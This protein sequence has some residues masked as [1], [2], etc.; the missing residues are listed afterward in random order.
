MEESDDIGPR[1]RM[2]LF[3]FGNVD[4]RG[5][6][7]DEY[8]N[9]EEL[10]SINHIDA[11]HV[12]EF[13]ANIKAIVSDGSECDSF[14][15]NDT[16]NSIAN[17]LP[18]IEPEDYYNESEL[19][20]LDAVE[21]SLPCEVDADVGDEYDETVPS[22]EFIVSAKEGELLASNNSST[23]EAPLAGSMTSSS[24]SKSSHPSPLPSIAS[25][26]LKC[27]P[28]PLSPT[29]DQLPIGSPRLDIPSSTRYEVG[30][31]S[32]IMPPPLHP[33]PVAATRQQHRAISSFCKSGLNH[34]NDPHHSSDQQAFP[35]RILNTPLGN[36]L[37]P[38]YADVDITALFPHY[39]PNL[40]PRWGRIISLPYPPQKYDHLKHNPIDYSEDEG[41]IGLTNGES[42]DV[43]EGIGRLHLFFRNFLDLGEIPTNEKQFEEATKLDEMQELQTF[44][45]PNL[46]CFAGAERSW[47]QI[48]FAERLAQLEN[49][50]AATSGQTVPKEV[51][52]KKDRKSRKKSLANTVNG[53]SATSNSVSAT[54]ADVKTKPEEGE[55]SSNVQ[56]R[57]CTWRF[58]P[59]K[60]WYDQLEIP[61]T[62]DITKWTEWRKNATLPVAAAPLQSTGLNVALCGHPTLAVESGT[63][64]IV[65]DSTTGAIA[66]KGSRLSHSIDEIDEEDM[67]SR[68]EEAELE[69]EDEEEMFLPFKLIQWEE[70]I[71]YDPQLSNNKDNYQGKYPGI[72]G[73]KVLTGSGQIG[74]SAAGMSGN[75]TS[76]TI[77][78]ASSTSTVDAHNQAPTALRSSTCFT[79]PYS[80]FPI[81]NPQI[82]DD[83][84]RFDI[85]YDPQC[86]TPAA[87]TPFLLTLNKNDE[88]SLLDTVVNDD[89]LVV[90]NAPSALKKKQPEHMQDGHINRASFHVTF[91]FASTRGTLTGALAKAEKGAE[92]VKRIL[93]KMPLS[94]RF[95]MYF[96]QNYAT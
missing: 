22:S 40:I 1:Y 71:I 57:Y 26:L 5:Q 2:C 46:N 30:D 95:V 50:S 15:S 59:A 91:G 66:Q 56:S 52:S 6:L 29:S 77:A 85:I 75:S 86:H 9:D 80:F 41:L 4:K 81:E 65:A 35:Q 10:S 76:S 62:A 3:L 33:A 68:T 16:S 94:F 88:Q 84:W 12:T 67:S 36:L 87:D 42:G 7:E 23:D 90:V 70:D 43:C 31:R 60:Y 11:C 92:K 83:S 78:S 74:Q 8:A 89:E 45:D 47:W 48:A 72:L 34:D 54:T 49:S 44:P 39:S 25:S 18:P 63:K 55:S 58:G 17:M 64:A 61:E 24:D 82:M 51:D 73:Y 93:G 13:E 37:P 69:A 21:N 20:C 28:E 96:T 32:T 27:W 19:I 14:V 38:E 79:G 53:D